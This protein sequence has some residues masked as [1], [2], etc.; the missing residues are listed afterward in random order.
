M[1]TTEK[2]SA[3]A[4]RIETRKSDLARA[5]AAYDSADESYAKAIARL[6]EEFKVDSPEEAQKLLKKLHKKAD[7]LYAQVEE[8]LSD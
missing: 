1:T 8:A 7:K 6:K 4:E 3:L 5:Q 2:M